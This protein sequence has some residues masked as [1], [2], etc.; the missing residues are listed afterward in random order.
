MFWLLHSHDIREIK[1]L[2][3]ELPGLLKISIMDWLG[4]LFTLYPEK[5]KGS[6]EQKS[7]RK[8]GRIEGGSSLV[9]LLMRIYF[10]LKVI[11]PKSEYD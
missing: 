5:G 4:I 3:L 1:I 9:G 8:S 6:K 11:S 10:L 7:G 2:C